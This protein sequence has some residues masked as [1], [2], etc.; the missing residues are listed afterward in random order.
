ML[1]VSCS[2]SCAPKSAKTEEV[3][4]VSNYADL[5]QAYDPADVSGAYRIEHLLNNALLEKPVSITANGEETVGHVVEI[6][7][8]SGRL[9]VDFAGAYGVDVPVEKVKDI[10]LVSK[11]EFEASFGQLENMNNQKLNFGPVKTR[12]KKVL[13]N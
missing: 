2:E 5:L 12:I 1:R 10:H 11:T 7:I 3:P 8:E 6:R 13:E 9:I 4:Q